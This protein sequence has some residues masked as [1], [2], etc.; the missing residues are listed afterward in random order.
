M[1]PFFG[2]HSA[3]QG[4]G[5]ASLL[6]LYMLEELIENEEIESGHI[7]SARDGHYMPDGVHCADRIW[8]GT[9]RIVSQH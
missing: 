5:R 1:C 7:P 9:Q 6:I 2:T 3:E 8:Q 4:P